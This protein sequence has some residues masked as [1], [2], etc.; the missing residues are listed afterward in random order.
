MVQRVNVV[1]AEFRKVSNSQMAETTKR[2]IRENA[3][4][5]LQLG[6][7]T[8]KSLQ[9]IQENDRLKMT[10]METQKKLELLEQNE[11]KLAKN[12]RSNLQV[13]NRC[14]DWLRLG[15]ALRQT[16]MPLGTLPPPPPPGSY[17]EQDRSNEWNSEH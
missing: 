14:W 17:V 9:L 5:S 2:T 10:L 4:L 3:T 7:I 13:M 8:E 15:A 16:G 12:N 11:K 1:A 6:K